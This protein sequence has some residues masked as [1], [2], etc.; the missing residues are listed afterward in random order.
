MMTNIITFHHHH[1][2]VR[3]I[4]VIYHHHTRTVEA[5]QSGMCD[6]LLAWIFIVMLVGVVIFVAIGLWRN[7]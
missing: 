2:P 5:T 3:A 6:E 7:R 1:M 4:P